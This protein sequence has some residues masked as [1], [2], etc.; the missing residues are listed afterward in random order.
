M[1]D[2]PG[3]GT[4]HV[5]EPKNFAPKDPPK[6]NPPNDDPITTADLA[7]CNGTSDAATAKSLRPR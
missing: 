2:A 4:G 3:A 1:A 7:K 6:L 5:E